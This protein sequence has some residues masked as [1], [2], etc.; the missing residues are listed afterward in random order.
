LKLVPTPKTTYGRVFRIH[1][2]NIA[3]RWTKS[4]VDKYADDYEEIA[5][6]IRMKIEGEGKPFISLVSIQ[7]GNDRIGFWANLHEPS[8][9]YLVNAYLREPGILLPVPANPNIL[10]ND[11]W[12]LIFE[13]N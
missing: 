12:D 5:A 11:G 2:K 7:H 3:I 4:I 6:K 8:G 1:G 9:C 13:D 10:Q